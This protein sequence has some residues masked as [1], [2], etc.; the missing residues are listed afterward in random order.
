MLDWAETM[1]RNERMPAQPTPRDLAALLFETM[2]TRCADHVLP[3]LAQ[4]AVFEFPGSAPMRGAR[5]ISVFFRALWRQYPDLAFTV[6]DM[7]V[8]GTRICVVW[9]NR[10]RHRSGAPYQN[11]GV[12]L[13][14]C[15]GGCITWISD[16]FKDTSFVIAADA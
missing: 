11:S 12:T 3:C 7:L 10:G 13:L 16:Y 6:S 15:D 4:D 1:H 8:D 14:R 2:N 9:T 5:R